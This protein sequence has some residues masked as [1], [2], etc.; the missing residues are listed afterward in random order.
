MMNVLRA[1]S[2]LF[3]LAATS[4][5]ILGW[6]AQNQAQERLGNA[7]PMISTGAY[8]MAGVLGVLALLGIVAVL[9]QR[10]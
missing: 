10:T 8:A 1:N 9:R 5:G 7:A 3:S 2:F 6:T 4:C